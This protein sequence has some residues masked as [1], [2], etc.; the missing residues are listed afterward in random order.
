M[1]SVA[2]RGVHHHHQ[3][4]VNSSASIPSSSV[5]VSEP[6]SVPASMPSHAIYPLPLIRF[7]PSSS[8]SP[9]SRR[10]RQSL[11]RARVHV[12]V[13]NDI[14]RALN[15]LYFDYPS[16][17]YVR[18]NFPSS[19]YSSAPSPS[20][21]QERL[22]QHIAE[23]A[24]SFLL[25]SRQAR[26]IPAAGSH[27]AIHRSDGS[28]LESGRF[29]SPSSSSSSSPS[30]RDRSPAA[31]S[32]DL[33]LYGDSLPSAAITFLPPS[34]SLGPRPYSLSVHPTGLNSFNLSHAFSALDEFASSCPPVSSVYGLPT[35]G[36]VKLR[37]DAVAL[38]KTLNALSLLS[39][40][41]PHIAHTYASPASLVVASSVAAQRIAAAGLRSPRVLAH[42]GEYVKL[43]KRMLLVGMLEMVASPV[44]VNGAFGVPKPDGQIRLILDARPANCWFA[45]PPHVSLPSPSHL[46]QLVVQSQQ[47]IWV[48]KL[49]LAN[50]YHQLVL[51]QWMRPFFCLPSLS[52]SELSSLRT[53][54]DLPSSIT[55]NLHGVAPLFPMCVTLPMG[56]SHA[57]FLAQCA[58]E[59]VL[60]SVS[61]LS[62][63]DNILNLVSPSLDRC[64]HSL[65]IDDTILMAP[66]KLEC[67]TDYTRCLAAYGAAPL[68]VKGEKLE[69]P[70]TAPISVLGVEFNGVSATLSLSPP[71]H[72]ELVTSTVSFL[73]QSVVT[74]RDLAVI[75]GG[76]TWVLL[77]SRPALSLLKHSY[78]FI[79]RHM[80]QPHRLWR[81][82]CRE[83]LVLMAIAPLLRVQLRR[84]FGSQIIATDASSYAAGVTTTASTSA[85]FASLWPLG[86]DQCPSLLS[87]PASAV[88]VDPPTNGGTP[89][90]PLPMQQPSVL[91]RQLMPDLST[92]VISCLLSAT[93]WTTIISSQWQREEHIN[94]LELHSVLL[95]VRWALSQPQHPNT[96][97]LLLTDSS[98]VYYGLHKGRSSA[99]ALLSLPQ[100]CGLGTWQWLVCIAC[101]DTISSQSC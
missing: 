95:A 81:C 60:Y 44:C 23:S 83:L 16:V 27:I 9:N 53:D 28:R 100:T 65:C 30:V 79:E 50:F 11:G 59:H 46:S 56:Y 90:A 55:T 49:D 66:T 45:D 12:Q 101:M 35:S 29:S 74:G 52:V 92:A 17:N 43:V 4:A 62:P 69:P 70:T 63:R 25:S 94:A 98:V 71:R 87:Q 20:P 96:R 78:R 6:E 82:V 34:L 67:D 64:I 36:I 15:T 91:F 40:L 48:A 86:S 2:E 89:V 42:R 31:S 8:L 24:S 21:A 18:R 77:L 68:L 93:R 54:P 73:Q 13:S 39:S 19:V 47:P 80:E 97:L 3:H 88:S 72:G 84:Q 99:S 57:V 5:S 41:P 10:A 14:I 85:L 38:P 33:F 1:P 61:A 7:T 37:A 58:H 22:L 26:F 76:W 32:H 51:P 75:I